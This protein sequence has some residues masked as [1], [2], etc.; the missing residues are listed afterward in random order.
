MEGCLK[1]YFAGFSFFIVFCSGQ[2]VAASNSDASLADSQSL[3]FPYPSEGVV[4]AQGFDSALGRK[5]GGVCVRGTEATLPSAAAS[6]EF[7]YIFDKEQLF[8]D[9]TTSAS[10]S[11]GGIG[12]GVSVSS[13]F[14]SNTDLDNSNTYILGS[15]IVDKGGKQLAPTANPKQANGE[16]YIWLADDALALLKKNNFPEFRRRCGDSFVGTIRSGGRYDALYQQTTSDFNKSTNFGLSI[17]AHGWGGSG[18]F[19]YSNTVRSAISQNGVTVRDLQIGGDLSSMPTTPTDV[20]GKLVSFAGFP[21]AEAVPYQI[22]VTPYQT[23]PNWPPSAATTQTSNATTREY[24]GQYLRLQDLYALYSRAANSQE[25]YYTPFLSQDDVRAKAT[26]LHMAVKCLDG[27]LTYCSQTGDC[28]P[29]HAWN[30]SIGSG[31]CSLAILSGQPA[32]YRSK[33]VTKAITGAAPAAADTAAKLADAESLTSA[34]SLALSLVEPVPNIRNQ[35]WKQLTSSALPLPAGDQQPTERTPF[36]L[37]YQLLASAPLRRQVSD[38]LHPAN[39]IG[40]DE[41]LLV[42]QVCGATYGDTRCTAAL[43]YSTVLSNSAE[44]PV[45]TGILRDYILRIRLA[46]LSQAFCSNSAENLMCR[47]PDE[48][49]NLVAS[50]P[51]NFGPDRGFPASPP[52]PLPAPAPKPTKEKNNPPP[53]PYYP[54]GRMGQFC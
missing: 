45:A 9:L 53:R 15:T 28:L 48:L 24:Y 12:F 8:N 50:L 17:S 51:V 43:D 23:L 13:N 47:V 4:L 11:Y 16:Q 21:E 26:V 49:Q 44:N 18:S 30:A 46:P 2:S 39:A 22:I 52:A 20:T 5:V 33:A 7:R 10:A 36:Y 1:K 14:V 29:A 38:A 42:R 37:Y 41:L 31:T 25:N 32:L 3:V 6:L 19:S 27:F 40:G 35:V 34:A 54:C